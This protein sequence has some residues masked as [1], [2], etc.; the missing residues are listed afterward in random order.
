MAVNLSFIGGAGW[1]FFDDNGV[2]LAGGKIYTYAAGT[3][4]PQTT[5]TSYDGT[6]PNAN[7]IILDAAGRTP[8]QIWATEGLLYKYVVATSA[9]VV[10][11][12]WDN[13][14]GSVVASDLAQDLANTTDNAKGDALIGFKQ[15]N[16]S[17]F[18]TG[19]TARTVSTKLQDALSVK[20]FGA[21]GNNVAD[22]TS[23]IQAGMTHVATNGGA[24]YFPEGTYK[25]TSSLTISSGAKPF[26]LF[27]YNTA[28]LVRS[29][30][31]G[32]MISIDTTDNWNIV[33]LNLDGGFATYPTNANHGIIWYNC[34]NTKVVSCRVTNY[35]NTAIIGY[36]TPLSTAY[37]NSQIIDC[38]VDGLSNAN[39]GVL[40]ADYVKSG[41]SGCIVQN[42][43]KTGSPCYALQLK[44][45]CQDSWIYSSVAINATVGVAAGNF[46][47]QEHV[48]NI[49][50]NIHVFNC[51]TGMAFGNAKGTVFSNILIDMNN[52]GNSAVDF[53]AG[54]V[55]CSGYNIAVRN[56]ATSKSA[57]RCRSGDTDNVVYLSTINNSDTASFRPFAEFNAGAE[58][59]TVNLDRY[60][61]PVATSTSTNLI[62]NTS[63]VATNQANYRALP[64]QT[65]Y[66]IASDAIS[67]TGVNVSY[68]RLDTE[69]S[70][71]TDDLLTINGGVD[72]QV[73]TLKTTNNTRD[74]VVKNSAAGAGVGTIRLTGAVDYTLSSTADRLTLQYDGNL[75]QWCEIGRGDNG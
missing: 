10:I 54:S 73:I 69:G 33:G 60:V 8:A 36:V 53:N 45:G 14:G 13:I 56:L 62:S 30:N 41:I 6:V 3:T 17:G 42:V 43:G 66:T 48:R 72:G 23:A 2:P 34:S 26:T 55:G 9:D 37:T 70:A 22:D 27:G 63:G 65:I 74:V 51:E 29:A 46:D 21:V 12:T 24:L 35:K 18:L 4:T 39:N 20:D 57:V 7:P 31:Y 49:I 61:S 5:Y 67:I 68:I 28:T 52:Q 38:F 19:A 47:T 58:R 71:A 64:L 59:N 50:G 44:N 11:R 15:A 25:V 1:Q 32:S 40:L 16:A 75:T